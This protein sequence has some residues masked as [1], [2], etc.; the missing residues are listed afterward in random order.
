MMYL[1]CGK[2]ATAAVGCHSD[3][4]GSICGLSWANNIDAH[5]TPLTTCLN[6][7]NLR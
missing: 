6:T 7:I 3:P 4:Q 2:M 5:N 1:Q